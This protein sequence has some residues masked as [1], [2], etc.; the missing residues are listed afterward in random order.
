MICPFGRV[1]FLPRG[2]PCVPDGGTCPSTP[3]T[4]VLIGGSTALSSSEERLA[5][6][7]SLGQSSVFLEEVL[8]TLPLRVGGLRLFLG[9]GVAIAVA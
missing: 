5:V 7:P 6:W 8:A 3:S 2:G 9:A 1:K 4:W